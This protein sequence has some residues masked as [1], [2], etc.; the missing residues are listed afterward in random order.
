MVLKKVGVVGSR[1]FTDSLKFEANLT[2]ILNDKG[3]PI[4]KECLKIVSGGAKGADTL[5]RCFAQKH[6][7]EITEYKNDFAKYGV[8]GY[9]ERNKQIVEDSDFIIA[10]WDGESRGTLNTLEQCKKIGKESVVIY[11]QL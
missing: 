8:R 11:C 4:S 7:L 2:Q 10:F 3:I 5:A 6:G 1:N 9:F